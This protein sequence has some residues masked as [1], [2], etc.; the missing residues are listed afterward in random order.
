M[1]GVGLCDLGSTSS[2]TCTYFVQR[3]AWTFDTTQQPDPAGRSLKYDDKKDSTTVS[4]YEYE[5]MKF[6]PRTRG[7]APTSVCRRLGS[8]SAVKTDVLPDGTRAIDGDLQTTCL[9]TSTETA[10][11]GGKIE[12]TD[13]VFTAVDGRFASP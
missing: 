3:V 4:G 11:P 1:T 5:A 13:Y 12:R 9:I 2:G 10:K 7:T 6:C 8:P